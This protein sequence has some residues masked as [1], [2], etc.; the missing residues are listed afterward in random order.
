[1][2]QFKKFALATAFIAFT[3]INANAL[4]GQV[5]FGELPGGTYSVDKNH[6]SITWKV[7]HM[8]LSNYT[9]RFKKFDADITIDPI[10]ITRS[11]VTATID[12]N[13]IE[14]DYVATEQEDFNKKLASDKDWFNSVQFPEIKFVSTKVE[15]TSATTGKITGNLTLLGVTKPVVLDATFVG[16]YKEH[17]M[18]KQPVVGF[19][20]FTKIKRSDFGFKNYIPLIGDE[21]AIQIEGEFGKDAL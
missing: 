21:V 1:M 4:D 2:T 10:D 7:N 15:K 19:S 14:T 11:T 9:A 13:S 20:A 16:A 8:G 5:T 17:P 12:P 6:A 3:T 18:T